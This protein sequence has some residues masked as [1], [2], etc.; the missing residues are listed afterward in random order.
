MQ[1]RNRKGIQSICPPDRSRLSF[2]MHGILACSALHLA[3]L[4]PSRRPKYVVEALGH[5]D[6]AI[7]GFRQAECRREELPRGACIWVFPYG[8]FSG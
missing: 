5:Q 1:S 6:R 8:V 3:Y 7:P 2:L 4:D